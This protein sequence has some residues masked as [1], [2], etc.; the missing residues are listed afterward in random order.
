MTVKWLDFCRQL[1]RVCHV[2][3]Y[4]TWGMFLCVLYHTIY[5][6]TVRAVTRF[7]HYF[8]FVWPTQ[9]VV[10]D[11]TSWSAGSVAG[12]CRS[13]QRNHYC[14]AVPFLYIILVSNRMIRLNFLWWVRFCCACVLGLVRRSIEEM[15]CTNGNDLHCRECLQKLIWYKFL[16][17]ISWEPWYTHVFAR[18]VMFGV[19]CILR[20]V[21]YF[22][23]CIAVQHDFAL[24][25]I[26]CEAHCIWW[27]STPRQIKWS[28][29]LVKVWH[30][31]V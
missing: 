11:G 6:Q 26:F 18:R 1:I 8:L 31:L 17:D 7:F 10:V 14:R 20:R 2:D 29:N 23:V 4:H 5:Y 9:K 13:C 3:R 21:H 25:H 28:H 19:S 27:T 12:S 24:L 16:F 30:A 22:S 15:I